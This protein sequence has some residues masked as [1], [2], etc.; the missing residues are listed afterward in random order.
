M[1]GTEYSAKR[2]IKNK[3]K[4]NQEP[5]LLPIEI[6]ITPRMGEYLDILQEENAEVIQIVSK[7]RRFGIH[8]KNPYEG[9]EARDNREQLVDEL[10]D[11]LALMQLLEDKVF[12]WPELQARADFKKEK[13][14]SYLRSEE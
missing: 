12:T 8:S 4:M 6:K 2:N 10:G 1:G 9:P 14:L 3:K 13:L 7:I 5:I 11:V